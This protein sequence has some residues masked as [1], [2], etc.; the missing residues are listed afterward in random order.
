MSSTKRN[1]LNVPFQEVIFRLLTMS[2]QLEFPAFY[3]LSV[4]PEGPFVL[5]AV[6]V[7]YCMRN[8]RVYHPAVRLDYLSFKRTICYW[9]LL[10][11]LLIIRMKQRQG[12]FLS[13]LQSDRRPSNVCVDY[14]YI[15]FSCVSTHRKYFNLLED[16]KI[17]D[18]SMK[19]QTLLGFFVKLR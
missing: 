2:R 15:A 10:I 5:D 1:R 3:P 18:N 9:N 19:F 6:T 4:F 8:I 12:L 13:G 14:L 7:F 16:M 17:S 11:V